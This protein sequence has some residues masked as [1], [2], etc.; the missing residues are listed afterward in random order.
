MSERWSID[1]LASLVAA[2]LETVNYE[3]QVSRRVRQTP[4]KRTIRF[5]IT[6][7]LLDRPLEMRGRTAY[8]GRR[9]VLQLAAIKQL[10]AKGMSL[11]EVQ[12][13]LAGAN[14][15]QL[16]EWS[17]IPPDFWEK[18]QP[19]PASPPGVSEILKATSAGNASLESSPRSRPFW[20]QA[21]KFSPQAKAAAPGAQ[22]AESDGVTASRALTLQLGDDVLLVVQNALRTDL[23]HD[24]AAELAAASKTLLTALRRLNVLS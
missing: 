19:A 14:D 23:N 10:Q 9:H 22:S 1:E 7:G 17:G 2:T 4:D 8:Y 5:Y 21:P 3:G 15:Q 16:A 24:E 12:A 20:I 6:L 18:H 11:V 13:A